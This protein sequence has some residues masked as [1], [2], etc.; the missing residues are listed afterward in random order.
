MIRRKGQVT[1]RP[2]GFP[3]KHQ[4]YN[5]LHLC[6]E[7]KMLTAVIFDMDGVLID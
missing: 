6:Q 2:L 1:E 7:Y 3:M 5:P 4:A